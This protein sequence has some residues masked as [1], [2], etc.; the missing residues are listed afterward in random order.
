MEI[1]K[2]LIASAMLYGLCSIAHAVPIIGD[3]VGLVASESTVTFS[4]APTT[5]NQ[6]LTNE[7][8]ALGVTLENFGIDKND[9]FGIVS[10]GSTGFAGDY[11]VWG[12]SSFPTAT[13]LTISFT[14]QVTDA[15]FATV[16]AGH[17][18]TFSAFLDGGLVESFNT[19]VASK[20]GSGFMGFTGILFDSIV[21]TPDA[22]SNVLAIDTLLF[23]TQQEAPIPPTP[24]LIG[25]GLIVLGFYRGK[26]DLKRRLTS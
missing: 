7:F 10:G 22:G 14:G 20:P 1:S 19:A 3:S 11:L 12:A 25:I 5:D 16:D 18:F 13:P 8:A 24:A 17:T 15:A 9:Q 4:E 21:I 26:F 23:N 6:V 2:R